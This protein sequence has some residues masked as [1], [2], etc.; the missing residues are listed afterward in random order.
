MTRSPKKLREMAAQIEQY[1]WK[2][3]KWKPGVVKVADRDHLLRCI[4]TGTYVHIWNE[5]PVHPA[6]LYNR[7][8]L[9][10]SLKR[11]EIFVCE[12]NPAAPFRF[13]ADFCPV[14]STWSV[15]SDE[16]EDLERHSFLTLDEVFCYCAEKL[17]EGCPMQVTFRKAK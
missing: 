16:V 6:W 9:D 3:R 12:R 10:Y 2:N 4:R 11:G 17:S 1:R 14:D 8:T 13:V 7:T 5:N 15:S